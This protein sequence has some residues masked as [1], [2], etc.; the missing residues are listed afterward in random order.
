MGWLDGVLLRYAVEINGITEL[1]VTKMD[2]L[3]GLPEVKICVGYRLDGKEYS[4]SPLGLHASQKA[5]FE[6]VYET[7]PGWK[8]NISACRDFAA[9]PRAA[10][11]YLQRIESISGCPISLVSV[12][13]ERSQVIVKPP[14]A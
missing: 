10:Q 13:P 3:S 11:T 8:E 6:P 9:L 7:L 12:G 2:I 4:G 14:L 5:H 1:A